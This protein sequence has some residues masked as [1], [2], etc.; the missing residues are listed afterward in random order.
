MCTIGYVNRIFQNVLNIDQDQLERLYHDI[1][2][3]GVIVPSGEGRSKGAL[4]IACSE[5]AKVRRGKIIV[6]R[7]DIGFPGRD[8]AEAAPILKHR[9]GNVSLLINS[10]SG[11]SL[12]PLIDAQKLAFYISKTGNYRDFKIDVVTSDPESPIGKIGVKYGTTLLLKGREVLAT[13]IEPK[14]FRTYGIMED[15]FILGSGVLF[16]S[17]AE[18][19]YEEAPASRIIVKAGELFKDIGKV[20]DDVINSDFFNSLLNMLEERTMCFFAGLGSS[21]E[22]ARMT[23]VRVGHVKRAL[24]DQVYVAGESNQP[25][26]RAGDVLIVISYSGETE[27]VAAWC[28]NFKR[29]GGK[30]ASIVGTPGSTIQS[31]SDI[32]FVIE[33]SREEG[34][35]NNFYIKAAF[36]LSP[37]PIYLVERVEERGLK[38]PEYILRWQHSVM[39]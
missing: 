17:I 30:V 35:P 23:A 20:V 36:A 19:M 13:T 26:P 3:A 34:K 14:E 16:H 1:T 22:V 11:K 21:Q 18:A 6:D 38:L 29:L 39:S 31:I 10:G 9:F 2:T 27:V 33:G 32:S 4:S 37:L 7:G 5:M 15:I 28:K 8:V 25:A 12:M 24:G